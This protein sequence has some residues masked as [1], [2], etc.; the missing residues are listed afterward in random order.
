[1]NYRH[2]YH[3]GSFADVVKH[4]VLALLIDQLKHK[5]AAFRVI[6]TH[7]GIGLYDL[8]A[9]EAQRTGEWRGGIGRIYDRRLGPTL[10][11]LLSPYLD[12]VRAANAGG[13]LAYYPGSPWIIR[14]ALRDHDRLTALELHG[15]D[16]ATLAQTFADDH[17]T[18]VIYLD[19]WL[20]LGSFVPPKER[21][22]L[23]LVDP[24]F[25]LPGEFERI[26]AGLQ[27]AHQRWPTGIFAFWYPV[28]D[29]PAIDRFRADLKASG[30]PRLLRAELTIRSRSTAATFN[31]TGLVLYNPP[32]QFAATLATLLGAL[33]PA[34]AAGPGASSLIDW[35]AGE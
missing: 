2:A 32:W 28:K 20:A 27:R 8:A 10:I 12:V 14:A 24:P 19:G 13:P 31:G 21:R 22:G 29:L 4:A 26:V 25:E 23:V 17:Q 9:P 33:V 35:I 1:M 7:A 34:L 3:A 15:A 11:D 6:D 18:K 30:I 5:D 16:A